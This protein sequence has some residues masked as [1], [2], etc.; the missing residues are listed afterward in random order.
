MNKKAPFFSLIT[1]CFNSDATIERTIKS[2]LAQTFTAYE[3]IIVDGGSKD[4]T[5]E[6]VKKYEPMFE[7]RMKWQSEPDSG[8]YNAMNKG[9]KRSSGTI[10]GIV[11]SDDWLETDALEI[12]HETAVK[13]GFNNNEIF[14]GN[15]RFHYK[16][17]K[18]IVHKTSKER[19]NRLSR[20]YGM[21][22]YHPATFV[23]RGVYE[24]IGLY[25]ENYKLCADTDFIIRCYK[26]G[27]NV[28]FI[29]KIISNMMDGGASNN[30]SKK[31][32]KDVL[33]KIRKHSKS[34]SEY[35]F[36]YAKCYVDWILHEITPNG[37]I[38]IYR[39]IKSKI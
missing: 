33:Y 1:V 9:I 6:I 12:V 28:I 29:D 32:L 2:V 21:G 17:G 24:S 34:R 25:D 5:L 13:G 30:S 14:T 4:S 16:L 31:V 36:L 15:L 27:I 8:I 3:Y 11:N 22:L 37:V 10:I 19:Y 23:S 38:E 26:A 18:S 7:G 35:I 20:Y 39:K